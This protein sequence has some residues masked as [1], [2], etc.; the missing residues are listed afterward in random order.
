MLRA[1]ALVFL[2]GW[3]LHTV[4]HFRRG[5]EVVTPYVLAAGTIS[6]V[7]ALIA[8][9]MALG[10][11]RLAPPSWGALSDSL[12][13]ANADALTWFAVV[14][15]IVGALAFGWVGSRALSRTGSPRASLGAH[16][17]SQSAHR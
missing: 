7:V 3:T 17:A 14:S 5:I 11:H 1:A 8:I 9:G 13:A 15:E 2:A 4:D 16:Q 10:G 12:S 6:G